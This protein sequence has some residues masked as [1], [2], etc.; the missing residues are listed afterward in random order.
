MVAGPRRALAGETERALSL[1]AEGLAR[2]RELHLRRVLVMA[3]VRA[4]ETAVLTGDGEQAR[5]LVCELLA[6]LAE[7]GAR[8]WVADAIELAAILLEADG[9][10]Q[11]AAHL[12][13]ACDALRQALG[14]PAAGLRALSP[15]AQAC[16]DRLEETLA[17]ADAAERAVP[18]GSLSIE[19][20]ISYAL[21]RLEP[22]SPS[23]AGHGQPDL[24]PVSPSPGR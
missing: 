7:L 15:T 17:G 9:Q 1:A 4:S 5:R 10:A 2:A 12:L 13:G 3:L 20:A 11:P 14:E 19:G 8:R 6:L 24:S 23:P 22:T 16:R 21:N 18:S